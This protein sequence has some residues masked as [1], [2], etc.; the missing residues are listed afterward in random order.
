[1]LLLVLCFLCVLQCCD[2]DG[3]YVKVSPISK[4]VMMVLYVWHLNKEQCEHACMVT[5][6][7]E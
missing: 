3:V 5:E 1:M 2:V 6:Y 7:C 4:I